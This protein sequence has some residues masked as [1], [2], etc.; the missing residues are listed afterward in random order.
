MK[1]GS[2]VYSQRFKTPSLHKHCKK[3]RVIYLK[4]ICFHK[5]QILGTFHNMS[6]VLSDLF[7]MHPYS[8]VKNQF[9]IAT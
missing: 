8:L 3:I 9:Y 6:L 1:Y 4:K 2:L 7:F 5:F